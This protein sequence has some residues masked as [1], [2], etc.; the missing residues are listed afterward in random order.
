LYDTSKISLSFAREIANLFGAIINEICCNPEQSIENLE[1]SVGKPAYVL[2]SLDICKTLYRQAASQCEVT[3]SQVLDIHPCTSFQRQQMETTVRK[4]GGGLNQHVFRVQNLVSSAVVQEAWTLVAAACPALRTRIVYLKQYGFCQVTLKS[5]P[6]WTEEDSL[7]EYLQW[8]KC[9]STR[10]GGP[11]CRFGKVEE[12]DD[13]VYFI[14]SLHRTI[15]DSWTLHTIMNAVERACKGAT[16]TPMVSLTNFMRRLSSHQGETVQ[17]VPTAFCYD[18]PQYPRFQ[19]DV[20]NPNISALS[21]INIRAY[22]DSMVLRAAWVLCLS[23]LTG[24]TKVCFGAHLDG[25]DAISQTSEVCGSLGTVVPFLFDIATTPTGESLLHATQNLTH[26]LVSH[27]KDICTTSSIIQEREHGYPFRN[28]LIIDK[29]HTEL[30]DDNIGALKSVQVNMIES[31]ASDVRLVVHCRAMSDKTTIEIRFDNQIVSSEDAGILLEQYRHAIVQLEMNPS[32]LLA[33][34]TPL[35]NH[36]IALLTDWNKE[37]PVALDHCVHDLIQLTAKD[38]PE[39]PAICSWDFSLDYQELDGLSARMAVLLQNEGYKSGTIVPYFLEKSAI[40]VVVM[41]AILRIGGTLL[42]LDIKH[43]AERID[44][45][46]SESRAYKIITSSMLFSTVKEKLG[47]RQTV[48][49][50]M[51]LI[52]SQLPSQYQRISVKPSD[53][54]YIIY[55]SGS[56]GTPKGTMITHSNF[57]TSVK[58]RR[59]LVKM[60]TSTRTLQYLN[61]IFD[62]S[63]FDVFLTLVSGGCVCLPSE[64][65]WSSDIAGAIRRTNSNFA[66]LT[67]SLATLLNPYE[68][69]TLRTLGLTGESCEKYV[70]EKWKEIR[71]LNMYGPA[72]ATVHSSGCDVSFGSGK[73]HLNIGRSGGCLYW[74]VNVADH[75]QLVPI[76]CPGELLIQGPIV[77]CGYMN[78]PEKTKAAFIDPPSWISGFGSGETL[79]RWYKTG[80]VV[81]QTA[82]GSVIYMGRKDTQ[83][84]L[85]GQRIELGDIEYHLTRSLKSRWELAVELVKP[86]GRNQEPCLV[87]FFAVCSPCKLKTGEVPCELLSPLTEEASELTLALTTALPSY[88]VPRFFVHMNG[89]PFTSSG[90][91]DRATLRK[92]GARLSPRQLS[93]YDSYRQVSHNSTKPLQPSIDDKEDKLTSLESQIRELWSETLGLPSETIRITDNFFNIG[94]SSIRAMRLSHSARRVGITLKVTEV[95]RAPVLSEMASIAS[96]EQLIAMNGVPT[97]SMD[98]TAR[99]I[100]TSSFMSS[101]LAHAAKRQEPYLVGGN[102]QSITEATDVQADMVAVG[103]L[104]GEA[105]HNEMIMG[106]QT[107]LDVGRLVSACKAIISHHQM[108]RTAFVQ[109]SNT[110]YQIAV[111]QVPLDDMITVGGEMPSTTSSQTALDIYLPH[112]HL[113]ELSNDG[114]RCHNVRLKIH[115]ALYDAI[116]MDIVLRDLRMVY[117]GDLPLKGPSFYDWVSYV[118]H[119]DLSN[120]E[121]FWQQTL[122]GSS[123]TYLVTPSVPVTPHFCRDSMQIRIPLRNVI[124]TYGTPS[125]VVQAAWALVLSSATGLDDVVFCAPNANRSLASFP[126]M[127]QV[128]GLCLNFL[129]ARARIDRQMTLGSLIQQLHDQAVAS[130]P[131]QHQGFRAIIKRCTDWPSWTRYSSMLIYQNHDSLQK[132]IRFGEQDCFLTPYGKFGRCADILIEATPSPSLQENAEGQVEMKDLVIDMLYSRKTFTDEQANWIL[133]CFTKVLE[134]IPKN[135]EQPIER[136]SLRPSL[137]YMILPPFT[138]VAAPRTATGDIGSN[139]LAK[140]D[141]AWGEVGLVLKTGVQ[142]PEDDSMFSSGADVVSTMLLARHY[143]QNGHQ[144]SMQDLINN[145]TRIS[146]SRLID[147]TGMNGEKT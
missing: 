71:V 127:D 47:Q 139:A 118:N 77:S 63:M 97:T 44:T 136:D 49:V 1:A 65:E 11:L 112:F 36:E 48:V 41:L 26:E 57:S 103:E 14:L 16:L 109:H 131:H 43:P 46:L 130:I 34:L 101:C 7:S 39:A 114:K 45:I 102:I 95:F 25:R 66:F 128:C 142:A 75:N 132:S 3:R 23:R 108:F 83:V 76:G 125:S 110:L 143:Q 89:L 40:A 85:S 27:T 13:T 51:E 17:K 115:H 87:V 30:L 98:Q 96:R 135:L 119:M 2:S 61:F 33:N 50:D 82:D 58:H 8:D 145:P 18:A 124:T 140:V 91:T 73:H 134:S 9:I 24:D 20:P 90:K 12:Q 144:I 105:W 59:D 60:S 10:Y 86:S 93:S 84:K 138:S 126:D 4:G 21:S 137:P 113:D 54:C 81:V 116:S 122:Q 29:S 72:E 146:Q 35:S 67:P 28:I 53:I 120:S 32:A 100:G 94:G 68:V 78:N 117:A 42:P 15:Y 31:S 99:L 19:S 70:I 64:D 37:M 38:S 88:M 55:T 147:N 52:R 69:P 74:V 22:T 133:Q 5:G 56:T 92:I 111:N 80:D 106:S 141:Q 123:M 6:D 62:V 121:E 129:P 79:E 104:D 107:G